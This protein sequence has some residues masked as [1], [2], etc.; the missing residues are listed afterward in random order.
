MPDHRD[1]IRRLRLPPRRGGGWPTEPVTEDFNF[2]D[3]VRD[4]QHYS[5]A[6]IS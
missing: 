3:L 1:F 4:E 2:V 6:E 5:N